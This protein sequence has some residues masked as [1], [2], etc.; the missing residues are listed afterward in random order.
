MQRPASGS[1][2]DYLI[3]ITYT[4]LLKYAY[5]EI[6][7]MINYAKM[8]VFEISKFSLIELSTV[9]TKVISRS[10]KLQNDLIRCLGT[11]TF[12]SYLGSFIGREEEKVDI[13]K[14]IE[15]LVN[16]KVNFTKEQTKKIFD[17]LKDDLLKID[18]ESVI[19]KIK[20]INNKELISEIENYS[21]NVIDIK[22]KGLEDKC[23]TFYEPLNT[24]IDQEINSALVNIQTRV[25][26]E[27]KIHKMMGVSKSHEITYS[28]LIVFIAIILFFILFSKTFVIKKIISC[29]QPR[30]K[31]L[32]IKRTSH[33]SSRSSS[34]S[35]SPSIRR[36]SRRS[37]INKIK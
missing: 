21:E 10:G 6:M 14:E 20:D 19:D 17:L 8:D 29:F 25:K 11:R 30:Q 9:I 15:T 34:R 2:A 16:K 35:K 7:T 4:L 23:P 36:S 24:I 27:Y 5:D 26:N 1:D 3:Y 13:M 18:V 37:S 28:T 33:R 31:A 32:T 22:Y 12:S